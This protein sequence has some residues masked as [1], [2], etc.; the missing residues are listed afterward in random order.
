MK[1]NSDKIC[2]GSSAAKILGL[3][4]QGVVET[5]TSVRDILYLHIRKA[6]LRAGDYGVCLFPTRLWMQNNG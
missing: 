5:G 2:H 3:I 1:S 6:E 4:L